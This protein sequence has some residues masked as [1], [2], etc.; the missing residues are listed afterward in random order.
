MEGR[1]AERQ[2]RERVLVYCL[3][4]TNKVTKRKKQKI[5]RGL[6]WPPISKKTH[7]NQPKTMAATEGTMER[8]RD[9]REVRGKWGTIVLM[10]L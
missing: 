4:A 10:A 6:R 8:R 1:R 5:R 3:G 2:A 9:E 7:N